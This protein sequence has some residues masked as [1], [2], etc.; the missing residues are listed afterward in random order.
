MQYIVAYFATAFVF[1]AID[2]VWLAKIASRFYADR[3]GHL[4]MDKPNLP[5][6]GGFYVMYVVGI[7]V[8]AVAPA[9]KNDSLTVALCYGALFGFFTYAT[10]DMTNYATLRGW[11]F[12]V[13]AVDVLWGTVLSGVSA[14]LGTYLT[15]LLLG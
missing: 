11:P 12:V 2:Y 4:L 7:V 3:I 1:L 13:V 15:R 6:A 5:A 8:F 14:L 10:Y 9:L